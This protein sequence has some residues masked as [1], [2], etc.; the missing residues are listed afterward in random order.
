MRTWR[1]GREMRLG[2]QAASNALEDCE[3]WADGLVGYGR[4]DVEGGG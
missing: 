2:C 4:V 1:V 3:A